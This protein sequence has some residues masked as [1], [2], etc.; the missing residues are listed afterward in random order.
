[1]YEG[2]VSV[3]HHDTDTIETSISQ[4]DINP[5][6]LTDDVL[7]RLGVTRYSIKSVHNLQNTMLLHGRALDITPLLK[8]KPILTTHDG[9]EVTSKDV[10]IW[11]AYQDASNLYNPKYK[12]APCQKRVST[13]LME[14]Y[15]KPVLVFSTLDA[16][17]NYI[18]TKW[19]EL[20]PEPI[21]VTE[22]GV[23]IYKGMKYCYCPKEGYTRQGN[24][25]K[26]I[27]YNT[28][29]ED[30]GKRDDVKYFSTIEITEAYLNRTWA[31]AE[32]DKLDAE[33]QSLLKSKQ[34]Q[35]K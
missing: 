18:N 29:N 28:A 10:M 8:P 17:I 6:E 25:C 20:H 34:C 35:N 2:V 4:N 26:I 13:F 12:D 33:Y 15:S 27:D 21:F 9:V 24:K 11:I 19:A 1:M 14:Q 5:I 3:R 22:D 31:K 32:A 30:S 23:G 7:N 16:C